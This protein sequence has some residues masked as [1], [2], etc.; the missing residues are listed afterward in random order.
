MTAAVTG[1]TETGINVTYNA[2][3]TYDFVVG[4]SP[5][6]THTSYI[7]VK[8]DTVPTAANAQAGEDFI[9]N[10]GPI[11]AY[12][13]SMH[14]LFYRPASEGDFT[15]VYI[16]QSG[17][18]NTQNQISA[19]TQAAAT[20]DVGGEDHNVLYSGDVLTGAGGFIVEVV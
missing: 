14:V 3:G 6:P 8:A 13:G 15:A 9:G 17:S 16:Y 5:T 4:A 10:S 18:P 1:N 20:V 7:N 2:D 11:P 19:W 12:A